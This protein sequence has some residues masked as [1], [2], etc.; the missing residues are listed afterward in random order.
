METILPF[1][2]RAQVWIYEHAVGDGAVESLALV[3]AKRPNGLL[4]GL[5][6]GVIPDDELASAQEAQMDDLVG[7]SLATEA[8]ALAHAASGFSPVPDQSLSAIVVDLSVQA[9]SRL[10]PLVADSPLELVVPFDLSRP[11]LVPDPAVLLQLALDWAAAAGASERLQYYSAEEGPTEPQPKQKRSVLRLSK[12][13]VLQPAASALPSGSVP[14]KPPQPKRITTA[15]LASQLESLSSTLPSLVRSMEELSVRQAAMEKQMAAG[16]AAPLSQPLGLG[17]R[18]KPAGTPALGLL[19]P[20]PRTARTN[21]QPQLPLMGLE[22]AAEAAAEEAKEEF[23]LPAPSSDTLS[24]AVLEQS[25]ALTTLVAQ[26]AGASGDLL[27]D[28]TGPAA[29]LSAR[30]EPAS[31]QRCRKSSLPTRESSM[32][33]CCKTWRSAW[34]PPPL[35]APSRPSSYSKACACPGTGN[36]SEALLGSEIWEPLPIPWLMLWT[37]CRRAG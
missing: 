3:L 20:P 17:I 29:H 22:G 9:V 21:P 36:D 32:Q 28:S 24:Q 34:P 25:R 19:G 5:P 14:Q 1:A 12:D 37:P 13:D 18:P 23:G 15:T 10:S 11:E 35:S 33:L 8:P 16:P 31:G 30:G 2:E 27:S 26:L 7:S 6:L 4:V